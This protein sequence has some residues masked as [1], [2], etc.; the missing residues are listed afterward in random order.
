MGQFF[1]VSRTC[2]IVKGRSVRCL[3]GRG[4]P[5]GCGVTLYVGE[6]S[7]RVQCCLLC[8]LLVFSH[9]PC[10]PQ[11]N[12][13]I[14]MLIPRW[15]GLCTS[16]TP[17]ISPMNSPVRR[18]VSPATATPTG[19]VGGFEASFPCT[20]ALDC[21]SLLLPSCSSWFIRTRMWDGPLL[22]LPP[23]LVHQLPPCQESSPPSCPSP[24]LP[25]SG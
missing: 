21:R 7:K 23:H 17:W 6:G 1:F 15:V 9:F 18:A 22:Q 5:R 12:W 10:Y 8:S 3:P 11:S 14:L 25:Q 20:G 24:P 4:N 16:R 13:P 19:V 2:Y